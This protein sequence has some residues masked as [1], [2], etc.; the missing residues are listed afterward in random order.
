M[1]HPSIRFFPATYSDHLSIGWKAMRDRVSSLFV[2]PIGPQALYRAYK[3][4]GG[5]GSV[6]SVLLTVLVFPLLSAVSLASAALAGTVGLISGIIFPLA[7]AARFFSNRKKIAEDTKQIN[8]FQTEMFNYFCASHE[9]VDTSV[10]KS[11]VTR[12]QMFKDRTIKEGDSRTHEYWLSFN[13]DKFSENYVR[14]MGG[15][16]LSENYTEHV[17][18]FLIESKLLN[19]GDRDLDALELIINTNITSDELKRLMTLFAGA[20][21][22]R[23]LSY[24]N[25]RNP[26]EPFQLF[27]GALELPALDGLAQGLRNRVHV[28]QLLMAGEGVYDPKSN[29]GKYQKQVLTDFLDKVNGLVRPD[30]IAFQRAV[31]PDTAPIF[32]ERNELFSYRVDCEIRKTKDIKLDLFL[33]KATAYWKMKPSSP[34]PSADDSAAVS[35]PPFCVSNDGQPKPSASQQ[36][37][38]SQGFQPKV[39]P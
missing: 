14:R 34:Q 8:A 21:E 1:L 7:A 28:F 16:F 32:S 33:T 19:V 24:A 18:H 12:Y 15:D 20:V 25:W 6:G 4:K 17:L 5:Y 27:S 10:I 31:L 22:T 2:R 30:L 29:R 38:A 36:E 26:P 3:D 23:E 13:V 11:F 9:G 35:P 37:G 39:G